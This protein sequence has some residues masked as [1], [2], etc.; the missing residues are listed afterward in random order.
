MDF[1]KRWHITLTRVIARFLYTPLSIAGTRLVMRKKIM[2]VPRRMLIAWLPI[3][4]NFE[5]IAL[6]H[7]A[8]QTFIAFGLLH[9]IWYLVESEVAS[10]K[11]S[12]KRS[13]GTK[14]SL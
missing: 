2:G 14:T 1:Y 4:I 5:V 3:L 12:G 6:W 7:G 11:R 13:G 10:G 8:A 9:G